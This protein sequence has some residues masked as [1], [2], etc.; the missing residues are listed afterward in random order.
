[1]HTA[2]FSTSYNTN[3]IR[4]NIEFVPIKLSVDIGLYRMRDGMDKMSMNQAIVHYWSNSERISAKLNNK[5]QS[6]DKWVN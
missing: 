5:Y 6:Y 3:F 4:S 2:M 1:M